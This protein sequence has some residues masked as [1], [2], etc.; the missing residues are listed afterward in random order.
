MTDARRSSIPWLV[1]MAVLAGVTVVSI[2]RLRTDKIGDGATAALPG[3][4]KGLSC[5]S[6]SPDKFT[7]VPGGRQEISASFAPGSGHRALIWSASGGVLMTTAGRGD[8]PELSAHVYLDDF[9]DG[10]SNYGLWRS[11]LSRDATLVER[12][13]RLRATIENG[14][15]DRFA[16][17]ETRDVIDGDF[18]AQITVLDVSVNG[19]RGAASLTFAMLDGNETHIQAMAGPG[20]AALEANARAFDGTWRTSASAVYGGGPV[21]LRIVRVGST[22][23]CFFDRGTGPLPLGNFTDVSPGAGHLRIETFRAART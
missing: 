9:D 1:G 14:N 21:H 6:L 18:A 3:A 16:R 15:E 22:F 7:V 19:A 13:G 8:K 12:V 2:V 4:P 11:E 10:T 5:T 20:Y 23:A 17:L